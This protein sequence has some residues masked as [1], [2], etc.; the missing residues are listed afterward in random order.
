[1]RSALNFRQ[2][3][4]KVNRVFLLA[5]LGLIILSATANAQSA[6]FKRMWIDYDV[7]ESGQ[8]GMRIHTEFDVHSM[9]GVAGVLALYFQYRNNTFLRDK[10]KKFYSVTGE[11][12]VYS[13]LSPCCNPTTY[14]QDLALFMPYAEL[15]LPDGNYDLRVLPQVLYKQ[16]GAIGI[17]PAF[18]FVYK[19]G[20][21]TVKK[22]PSATFSRAWVD[23]DVREGG[24][25]GMR[26]HVKFSTSD[27]KDTDGKL[28]VFIQKRDSTP[29]YSSNSN[30]RLAS[31]KRAG[32]MVGLLSIR[33]AFDMTDYNDA[34]VFIPYSQMK[35]VLPS[36]THNL[37]MD[38]DV[39]YQNG[40]PLQHLATQDF[41]FEYK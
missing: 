2:I 20:N 39:L 5:A 35:S 31:G 30:Y 10:N 19:Q 7:T 36:G 21:T 34:F 1:M 23:Y 33:P 15:D 13:D 37:Q 29:L 22:N 9:K 32:E 17:F 11:V 25:K 8:K 16:G 38:I 18:D 24:V 4:N 41:W 14:Y 40:D 12:A 3:T 26:V 28:A 27:M 6:T